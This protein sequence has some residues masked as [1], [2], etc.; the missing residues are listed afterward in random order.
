MP[1]IQ[2]SLLRDTSTSRART[3]DSVSLLLC[4]DYNHEPQSVTWLSEL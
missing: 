4:P 1:Y 2:G 3:S